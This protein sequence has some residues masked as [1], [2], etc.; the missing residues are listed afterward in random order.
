MCVKTAIGKWGFRVLSLMT[1]V[2][3]F[4]VREADDGKSHEQRDEG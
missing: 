2:V 3:L 1:H 4:L